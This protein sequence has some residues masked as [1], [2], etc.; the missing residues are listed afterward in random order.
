M[1]DP[2]FSPSNRLD[3]YFNLDHAFGLHNVNT[4]LFHELSP[5]KLFEGENPIEFDLKRPVYTAR[6]IR[7]RFEEQ[8]AEIKSLGVAARTDLYRML[9][10]ELFE[11]AVKFP[12]LLSKYIKICN[13]IFDLPSDAAF[14]P[15]VWEV[16]REAAM[17]TKKFNDD[18]LEDEMAAVLPE[19]FHSNPVWCRK[20][21]DYLGEAI[22]KKGLYSAYKTYMS[23]PAFSG[24]KGYL[25]ENSSG[26]VRLR[27]GYEEYIEH[28]FKT[29]AKRHPYE[30]YDEL[31]ELS[32]TSYFE[33]E[34]FCE[35]RDQ[36]L[37]NKLESGEFKDLHA[38]MAYYSREPFLLSDYSDAGKEFFESISSIAG[39]A[40]FKA[41]RSG[42]PEYLEGIKTA[43][44]VL[45]PDKFRCTVDF[46]DA[47]MEAAESADSVTI[48]RGF[49]GLLPLNYLELT[50][51]VCPLSEE[52]QIKWWRTLKK[53]DSPDQER[54]LLSIE[55]VHQECRRIPE[56]LEAA[57]N[58]LRWKIYRLK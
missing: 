53:Q 46:Y 14:P 21:I 48:E 3:S 30:I 4:R 33:S 44:R 45:L 36:C 25:M 6:L 34:K 40:V 19:E 8:A 52:H 54:A 26:Y 39:D 17:N 49:L 27:P 41:L 58:D 2:S 57:L 56:D 13:E 18:W 23:E 22:E 35:A 43:L 51:L 24:V 5:I 7:E 9:I 42:D 55:A 47:V 20:R 11:N 16:A 29:G 15:S 38:Y 31:K 37:I 50:G 12:M 28:F 32:Y 10:V 1:S